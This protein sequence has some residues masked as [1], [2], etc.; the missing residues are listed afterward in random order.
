MKVNCRPNKQKIDDWY[1]NGWLADTFYRAC[2]EVSG[3][4]VTSF[5][6]SD[7]YAPVL[8]WNQDKKEGPKDPPEWE[9]KN[10]GFSQQEIADA[11]WAQFG[12]WSFP[13]YFATDAEQALAL[14]SERSKVYR[15]IKAT[16]IQN[17]MK[18][19]KMIDLAGFAYNPLN[20][21]D[22]H[23]MHSELIAD[24]D[25]I[26]DGIG[27]QSAASSTDVKNTHKVAPYDGEATA[28]KVES[29]DTTKGD[30]ASTTPTV[31]YGS[32]S[33][34]GNTISSPSSVAS[35]AS[36]TTTTQAH[37]ETMNGKG[38][39]IGSGT[40]RFHV[41]AKDNAFGQELW[42]A[43]RYHAVKNRRYGNIGVTKTQELIE[44]EREALRFNLLQEFFR[45]INKVV[46]IGVY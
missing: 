9:W 30:G 23:E 11:Y 45:D 3:G 12:C 31:T 10:Y 37:M 41:A 24:G 5:F 26:V 44:A 7:I 8:K 2:G 28:T 33:Y 27:V 19:Q 46:L 13:E 1:W 22:A 15:L 14:S 25:T 20:N 18:Y 29:E 21:V 17:K 6:F 40:E 32:Q 4:V 42:G 35:G 16:L 39:E 36:K 43:D 38:E 34:S